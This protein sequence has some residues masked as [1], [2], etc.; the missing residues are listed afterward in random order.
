MMK[1]I[2]SLVILLLC[3]NSYASDR[4]L[5]IGIL[6]LPDNINP[7]EITTVRDER[8][9]QEL[10]EGLVS[11]DKNGNIIPGLASSWE[12]DDK[13][14]KYSFTLRD[15][16]FWSDGKPIVAQDFVDTYRFAIKFRSK[17]HSRLKVLKNFDAVKNGLQP[18]S[19]LGATA[20]NNKT[21]IIE[22]ALP[23]AFFDVQLQQ[24]Q[25]R[26]LPLHAINEQDVAKKWS[27]DKNL[28]VSGPYL[29]SKT[30]KTSLTLNK[31]PRYHS[32]KT[33]NFHEVIFQGYSNEGRMIND[34]VKNK[35]SIAEV[36]SNSRQLAWLHKNYPDR[37]KFVET[38]ILTYLA[39]NHTNPIVANLDVRKAL[40][41]AI[42]KA[43]LA[44]ALTNNVARYQQANSIAP[45]NMYSDN[46]LTTI[47]FNGLN[48]TERQQQAIKLLAKAG[49]SEKNK[50]SVSLYVDNRE[51][52]TKIGKIVKGM[53]QKIG[54]QTDLKIQPPKQHYQQMHNNELQIALGGWSQDYP[55]AYNFLSIL[56]SSYFGEKPIKSTKIDTLMNQSLSTLDNDKRDNLYLEIEQINHDNVIKLPLTFSLDATLVSPELLGYEYTGSAIHPS[57]WLSWKN[58]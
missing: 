3:F 21:L 56:S 20:L 55:E 7:A 24:V 10:Y 57:Q 13:G 39:F 54:V 26:P 34:L 9:I 23:L 11:I 5:N 48:T 43:V 42:D 50:L 16:L 27:I 47:Q 33:V 49:Y 8:L 46:K 36:G 18:A 15:N 40:A 12:I 1:Y 35:I 17:T 41:L 29:I 22:L 53:W 45:P 38:S 31:N 30:D 51:H 37:L 28:P 19:S 2:S 44:K 14:T 6:H 25:F 4:P 32:P 52:R 58:P